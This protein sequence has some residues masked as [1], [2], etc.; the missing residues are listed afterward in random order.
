VFIFELKNNRLITD[1][2]EKRNNG[3][4][5]RLDDAEVQEGQPVKV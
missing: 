1:S 2:E 5:E 3:L 4:F